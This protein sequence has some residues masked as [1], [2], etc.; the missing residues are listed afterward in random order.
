MRLDIYPLTSHYY[1]FEWNE[2][3]AWM[4]ASKADGGLRATLVR[5]GATGTAAE[6]VSTFQFDQLPI[7]LASKA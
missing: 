2:S 4:G 3:F 7:N 5:V 6:V 1:E